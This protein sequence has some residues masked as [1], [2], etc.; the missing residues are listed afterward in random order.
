[1]A[2]TV[3]ASSANLTGPG[4]ISGRIAEERRSAREVASAAFEAACEQARF[5]SRQDRDQAAA[6]VAHHERLKSVSEQHLASLVGPLATLEIASPDGSLS[7]LV[8]RAP[9]DGTIEDRIISDAERI[10]VGQAM[11]ILANTERLWVL[12]EIRERDWKEIAISPGESIQVRTAAAAGSEAFA[13]TV[14]HFGGT[15]AADT[16]AIS[17]VAEI[18]NRQGRFKPGMFGWVTVKVGADSPALVVPAAAIMRQDELP[19]VFVPQG[20]GKYRRVDVELGRET[21]EWV[22]VLAGLKMG[23]EV[24]SKGAFFLKSELLL[25]REE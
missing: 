12:V 14:R 24:V 22:E 20:D 9:F 6:D 18:D 5:D 1:L 21:G 4:V 7:E 15:V 17:L 3:D 25:E 23:D 11:F 8:L 19:F 16:R 13:G 2:E 10:A